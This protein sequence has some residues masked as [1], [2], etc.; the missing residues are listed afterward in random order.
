MQN[1][2]YVYTA[3]VNGVL[4]YVG[5]GK[6]DRSKHCTSGKSSCIA[7]NRELFNG[8]DIVVDH[9]VVGITHKEASVIEKFMIE[10]N[11]DTLFNISQKSIKRDT[12]VVDLDKV[13]KE[14]VGIS[15]PLLRCVGVTNTKTDRFVKLSAN[16]KLVYSFI[17]HEF[18]FKGGDKVS[19]PQQEIGD[20]LA[21][22][23]RTIISCLKTLVDVGLI[24][25]LNIS[26]NGAIHNNAYVVYD[27]LDTKRFVLHGLKQPVP[28]LYDSTCPF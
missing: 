1:N 17:K 23:K 14:C 25:V 5:I 3:K 7:L 15:I 10:S 18:D 12:E 28:A 26:T 9:V 27:V 13:S 20:C 16:E 11:K 8:A 19:F 21:L 4:R 6:E 2:Y 24:E 22:S